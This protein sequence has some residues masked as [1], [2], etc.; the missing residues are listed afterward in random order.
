MFLLVEGL[1]WFAQS[2][3]SGA[4]TYFESTPVPRQ[5][6]MHEALSAEAPQSFAERYAQGMRGW[7]NETEM[8]DLDD[9]IESADETNNKWLWTIA[10]KNRSSLDRLVCY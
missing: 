6:A 5:R 3:R 9:W 7:R 1:A 8:A 10:E 4:W 2:A